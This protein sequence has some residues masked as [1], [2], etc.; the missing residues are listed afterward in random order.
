MTDMSTMVVDYLHED[1]Q[2]PNKKK[3]QYSWLIRTYDAGAV[4]VML[5]CMAQE[6]IVYQLRAL[7]DKPMLCTQCHR[8]SAQQDYA[9]DDNDQQAKCPLCNHWVYIEECDV[10]EI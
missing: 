6:G 8:W 7:Y 9:L 5:E 3:T 2:D 1:L 4:G 10:E